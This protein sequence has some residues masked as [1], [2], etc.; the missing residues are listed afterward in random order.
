MMKLNSIVFNRA[1]WIRYN[2]IPAD[3]FEDHKIF[4]YMLARLLTC[5]F[6]ALMI[7]LAYFIV[8][9]LRENMGLWAALV[10]A[11]YPLFIK[12]SA[13]ATPDVPL[14]AL[15]LFTMLMSMIYIDKPSDNL[16]YFICFLVGCS[17]S[18][19]YPGIVFV[20]FPIFIAVR[21][22][23]LDKKLSFVL[24]KALQAFIVIFATVLMFMPNFFTNFGYVLGEV[25]FEAEH[26]VEGAMNYGFFGNLG[27][28]ISSM[29]S[30]GGIIF[31]LLAV[32]GIV[33]CV[34]SKDA[35][36][37]LLL[38]PVIYVAFICSLKLQWERWGMPMYTTCALLSVLGAGQLL[39]WIK[40]SLKDKKLFRVALNVAVLIF[41]L[42]VATGAARYVTSCLV[43]ENRLKALE[44]CQENGITEENAKYDGYSP[45]LMDHAMRIKLGPDENGNITVK[46]SSPIKYAIISSGTYA[47]YYAEPASEE[48]LKTRERYDA[49]MNTC[50]LIA[51]WEE[52]DNNSYISLLNTY[53]NITETI[54][55][56]KGGDCGTT[57]S[58]YEIPR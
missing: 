12:H 34:R 24:W 55:L 31:V 38:L 26:D 28:Y 11:I 16:F 29:L 42:N 51:K 40:G 36:S 41:L 15:M 44:Y 33:W 54:D 8:E 45:F 50:K 30:N 23:I 19:K 58:I 52:T 46:E 48:A 3:T 22:G 37:K 49:I 6:G 5:L 20:I 2:D 25:L 35:K 4:Y 43:K 27:F 32:L 21:K 53:Y 7:V 14:C 56:A 10:V 57:I 1:C 47:R 17:F 13:Y 9:R 18:D 39:D